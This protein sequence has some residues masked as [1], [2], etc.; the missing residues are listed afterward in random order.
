MGCC[1]FYH[2]FRLI[3]QKEWRKENDACDNRCDGTVLQ[4]MLEKDMEKWIQLW[5]Q[6][7]VFEH[8][9]APPGFPKK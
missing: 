3:G 1:P 8:P 6:D 2:Y 4:S 5:D 9:Y 7:A